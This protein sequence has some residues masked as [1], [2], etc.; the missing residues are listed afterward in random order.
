MSFSTSVLA[1]KKLQQVGEELR[2]EFM[3]GK[4]PARQMEHG[5]RQHNSKVQQTPIRRQFKVLRS[6]T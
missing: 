2:A 5:G 1:R 3:E 6:C 4:Q